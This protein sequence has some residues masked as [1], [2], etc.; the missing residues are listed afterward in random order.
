M[1]N[2]NDNV[3]RYQAAVEI[4]SE[5]EKRLEKFSLTT[6][7]AGTR[8]KSKNTKENQIKCY[9]TQHSQYNAFN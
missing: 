7:T 8:R 2:A 1:S 6:T 9:N 3:L 4:A 5:G